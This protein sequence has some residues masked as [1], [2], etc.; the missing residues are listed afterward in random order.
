MLPDLTG[1]PELLII[2]ETSPGKLAEEG[3]LWQKNV[4]R[5]K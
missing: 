2:P 5:V 3:L 1:V 4:Y